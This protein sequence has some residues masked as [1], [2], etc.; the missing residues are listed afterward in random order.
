M[1]GNNEVTDNRQRPDE[2]SRAQ[3]GNGHLRLER[4]HRKVSSG[5][6]L[7]RTRLVEIRFRVTRVSEEKGTKTSETV[8]L[9]FFVYV[10]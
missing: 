8:Y 10:S 6:E 9:F 5:T 4:F 1:V 2:Q 7:E 3:G